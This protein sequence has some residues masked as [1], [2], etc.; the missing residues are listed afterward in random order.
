LFAFINLKKGAE[1]KKRG[2]SVKLIL[3]GKKCFQKRPMF[4]T[5]DNNTKKHF[6][7][8]E[9]LIRIKKCKFLQK[10]GP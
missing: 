10:S 6:L 4:A 2:M 8:I 3:S 9:L 7:F 5:T 1:N